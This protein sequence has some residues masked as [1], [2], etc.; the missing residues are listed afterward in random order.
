M[1]RSARTTAR[2]SSDACSTQKGIHRPDRH[3]GAESDGAGGSPAAVVIGEV[4]SGG[5]ARGPV[6][7]R[8]RRRCDRG[9]DRGG[10]YLGGGGLRVLGCTLI[11]ALL[12]LLLGGAQRAGQLGNLRGPEDEEDDYDQD[13][14]VVDAGELCWR[15]E[16]H[17]DAPLSSATTRL[18]VPRVRCRPVHQMTGSRRC[19]QPARKTPRHRAATDARAPM[20]PQTA[21]PTLE[22]DRWWRKTATPAISTT[23]IL[24]PSTAFQADEACLASTALMF[25]KPVRRR[26]P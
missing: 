20:A 22:V 6:C 16:W 8:S 23:A 18:D 5:S 9:S 17:D 26:T 12:E 3:L 10:R 13:Q 7:G 14:D 24:I 19:R 4:C 1:E 15:A 25:Q 21:R 2:A 11:E